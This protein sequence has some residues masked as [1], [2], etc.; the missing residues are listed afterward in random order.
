MKNTWRILTAMVL[1]L[2]CLLS[3]AGCAAAPAADEDDAQATPQEEQAPG[4]VTATDYVTLD[5]FFVD[6]SYVDDDSAALKMVYVFL[7]INAKDTNLDVDCKYTAL[8][9][10]SNSYDSDFYKG[11]CVYMPAYY[12]SSFIEDVYVGT[13]IKLALTF[14]VPEADLEAGKEVTLSD[15]SMPLSDLLF[16]TDDLVACESVEEIGQQVDPTGAAEEIEKHQVA[17]EETTKQV[18]ELM[19]GYYWS[20]QIAA[21]TSIMS[22]KIEFDDPNNFTVSSSIG[23]NSGTYEVLN[24]YI[25]ITYT[26]NNHSVDIPYEI[27]DGDVHLSCN[28][29]FS[30]YE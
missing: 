24:G 8:K 25:R 5:G 18:R 12:Y 29:A 2:A 21:G 9:I 23:S 7:T 11:S 1:C 6:N 20:F 15:T 3:F 4:K 16:S 19:N 13:E 14:K 22:N 30:I 10:G 26:S 27:K 17:D 28:E